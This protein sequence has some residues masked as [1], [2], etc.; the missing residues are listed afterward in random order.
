MNEAQEHVLQLAAPKIAAML[1]VEL[2]TMRYMDFTKETMS[3]SSTATNNISNTN[4][5]RNVNAQDLHEA[6]VTE[7]RPAEAITGNAIRENVVEVAKTSEIPD[8]SKEARVVEEVVGKE[9][10]Q[11]S[12]GQTTMTGTTVGRGVGYMAS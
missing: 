7:N 2:R 5:N 12:A 8:V 9:K 3:S 1:S 4:L 6:H 10:K 11:K